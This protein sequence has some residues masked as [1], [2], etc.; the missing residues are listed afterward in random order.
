MEM[1]LTGDMVP[2]AR[3]AEMGLIN[4]VV[5]SAELRA[6]SIALATKIT[7]KSSLT[8]ATGKRAFDQ[9]K[10]KSLASAYEYASEVMVDNMLAHDAQEGIAAFMEKRVPD[11]RDE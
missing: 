3:A 7:S 6:A 8:V 2:A 4:Q 1:L 5:P 9:Q 10:E 11:W